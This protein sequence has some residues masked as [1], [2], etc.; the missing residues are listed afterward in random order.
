MDEILGIR[1]KKDI[2]SLSKTLKYISDNNLEVLFPNKKKVM[3]ILLTI[4][5]T[6]ASVESAKSALRLIKTDYR[7]TMSEDSFKALVSMHAHWDINVI[8]IA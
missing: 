2:N 1:A 8:I 4:S 3:S 6:S 7:S 5:T